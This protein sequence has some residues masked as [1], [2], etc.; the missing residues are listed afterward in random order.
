MI[1]ILES[2]DMGRVLAR[3]AARMTEAEETVRP[4]L[5][6]VRKRGDK[7]LL[8]YARR[9][10]GL[11]RK[12]VRVPAEEL[13]PRRRRLTPEFRSAV[14]SRRGQCAHVTPRSS[15]RSESSASFGPV[16]GS[17]RLCAR[18]IPSP[19]IYPPADILCPQP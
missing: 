3:R 11:E 16:C 15:C 5:E 12:S 19:P 17:G 4:I 18:S 7:G 2:K 10:D 8:E 14:E 6:A 9:F 13:E 1:R